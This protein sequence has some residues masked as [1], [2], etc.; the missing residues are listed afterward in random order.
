MKEQRICLAC[1]D[2]VVFDILSVKKI[3]YGYVVKRE[4]PFGHSVVEHREHQP[5]ERV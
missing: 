5:Y 1:D 2:S 3:F 4:C